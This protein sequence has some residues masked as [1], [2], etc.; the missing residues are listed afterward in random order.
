MKYV[1]RRAQGY[2]EEGARQTRLLIL[3]LEGGG[4]PLLGDRRPFATQM[5]YVSERIHLLCPH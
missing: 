2:E 3:Y 1:K 4:L 5:A